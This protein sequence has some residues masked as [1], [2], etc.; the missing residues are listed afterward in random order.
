MANLPGALPARDHAD[1]SAVLYRLSGRAMLKLLA[2]VWVG[3]LLL[4][5][6]GARAEYG[7]WPDVYDWLVVTPLLTVFAMP[8]GLLDLSGLPYHGGTAA[9]HSAFFTFWF[10]MLVLHAGALRTGRRTYVAAIVA[11]LVPAAWKWAVHAV[12]LMGI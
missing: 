6:V 5:G 7:E 1:A 11:F 8:A 9:L 3:A 12:G 10:V 2:A 4:A